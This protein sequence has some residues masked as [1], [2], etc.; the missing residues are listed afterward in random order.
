MKLSLLLPLGFQDSARK[1]SFLIAIAA[2]IPK[3][4]GEP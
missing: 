2:I 3:K 4:W 1:Q